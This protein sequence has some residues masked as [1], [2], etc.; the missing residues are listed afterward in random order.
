V[1]DVQT[2]TTAT[3]TNTGSSSAPPSYEDS[4]FWAYAFLNDLNNNQQMKS[5]WT[6]LL[7]TCK[8]AIANKKATTQECVEQIDNFLAD[9]GYLTTGTEVLNLIKT[10]WWEAYQKAGQP[11]AASDKFV[12]D[13]LADPDL[14]TDWSNDASDP[15]INNTA[16]LDNFLQ[17]RGYDCTALQVK[18]SFETMRRHNMNFWTGLYGKTT[19]TPKAGG[20]PVP[21]PAVILY[22]ATDFTLGPDHVMGFSYNVGVLSWDY[23]DAGSLKTNRTRGSVTFSHATEPRKADQYVGNLFSGT[24]ELKDAW[25]GITA[26][27]YDFYGQIGDPPDNRPGHVVTPPSVN[28]QPVQN[29][30]SYLQQIAF[31]GGLAMMLHWIGNLTGVND[32]ISK[33]FGELKDTIKE[34]AGQLKDEFANRGEGT[35]DPANYEQSTTVQQLKQEGLPQAD[36]EEAISKA[37]ANEQAA[38]VQAEEDVS[39]GSETEDV[40]DDVVVDV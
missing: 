34:K 2:A 18:A 35:Q 3:N 15:K 5:D 19:L 20:Q 26:G 10:D 40:L 11:N 6:T 37:K 14:A 33:K 36:E 23:G 32:V 9:D 12:Q 7:A 25:Q 28:K 1:A 30:Q 13:L 29:W 39:E 38:D 22:G 17:D 21:G 27:S 4:T 16:T 8:D 24:L 31:Y